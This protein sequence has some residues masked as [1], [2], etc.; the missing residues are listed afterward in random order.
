ML[1]SEVSLLNRAM[2][3]GEKQI[4]TATLFYHILNRKLKE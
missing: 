3:L 1:K 4:Q 2:Q